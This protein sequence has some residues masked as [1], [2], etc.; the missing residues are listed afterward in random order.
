MSKKQYPYRL[1]SS[2]LMILTTLLLVVQVVF[3]VFNSGNVV[4]KTDK[5]ESVITTA[6]TEAVLPVVVLPFCKAV[7]SVLLVVALLLPV[8]LKAIKRHKEYYSIF[9]VQVLGSICMNGP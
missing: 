1:L 7:F 8:L 2:F 6:Q 9:N 4:S 3:A 5:K